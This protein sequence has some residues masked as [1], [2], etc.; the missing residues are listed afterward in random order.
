MHITCQKSGRK[1]VRRNGE[2]N[3]E[4][5]RA[6]GLF[7]TIRYLRLAISS[8][9]SAEVRDDPSDFYVYSVLVAAEILE[10]LSPLRIGRKI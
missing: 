8:G 5:P 3:L 6:Y 1:Q 4:H 9:V 10:S 7:K 2:M